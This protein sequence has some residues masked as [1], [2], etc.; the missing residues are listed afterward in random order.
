MLM[1]LRLAANIHGGRA[2]WQMNTRPG[3]GML[4]RLGGCKGATCRAAFQTCGSRHSATDDPSA[5]V[6]HQ[7]VWS[8]SIPDTRLISPFRTFAICSDDTMRAKVVL[9]LSISRM[10]LSE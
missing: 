2:G 1:G 8:G 4:N 9:S 6:C 5:L 3:I 10:M 7:R